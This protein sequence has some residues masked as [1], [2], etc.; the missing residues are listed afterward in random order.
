MITR[1]VVPVK[2]F[3][4]AKQRLSPTLTASARAALMSAMLSDT[5]RA[6]CAVARASEL[7]VITSDPGARELA[8]NHS[9]RVL[10]DPGDGDTVAASGHS[11]AARH[12]AIAR[13]GGAR[14]DRV[15]LVA[16]DCPLVNPAEIDSLLART[17]GE[18]ASV[19][20]V[21]DRNGT[22]TNALLLAPPDAIEPAFGPGSCRRHLELA[23]ARGHTALIAPLR[24]LALDIDT[25]DDLAAL[26]RA[27]ATAVRAAPATR[28]ALDAIDA[29]RTGPETL[30]PPRA[31]S[32][33]RAVT[34]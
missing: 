27:L 3:A 18:R 10:D 5:L 23:A 7:V 21:P 1:V 29:E 22:G 16:A 32:R 31:H 12:G 26:R 2:R 19:H 8:A 14:A 4:I 11:I 13:V 34:P 6:I 28:R 9:A 15:L 25:A 17:H 33:D 20:V 24:S 30:G